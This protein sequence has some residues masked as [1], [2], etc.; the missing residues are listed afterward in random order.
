MIWFGADFHLA[1]KN[2]IK[3]CNRPFSDVKTMDNTILSNFFKKVMPN[4]ILYFLGDLSF[5][6]NVVE[7]FF[8]KC[9]GLV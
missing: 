5:K 8:Q 3:Y 7:D 6:T 2:I 9:N 4:D 1:H